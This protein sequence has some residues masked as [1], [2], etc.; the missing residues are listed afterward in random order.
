M[1]QWTRY[2]FDRVGNMGWR[3]RFRPW[4]VTPDGNFRAAGSEQVKETF[5]Y[6]GLDRLT[7]A[8]V[9]RNGSADPEHSQSYGYDRLGNLAHKDTTGNTYGYTGCQA[10]ARPAGP[11]AVC[12]A[13]GNE[14][15]YD[16]NGNLTGSTGGKAR[17]LEY[18]P[19]NKP[20]EITEDGTS[21]QFTYG[22]GRSRVYKSATAGGQSE[23]S[24][25]VGQ[26]AEGGP[27]YRMRSGSGSD[28]LREAR[29]WR[30]DPQS[31]RGHRTDPM[32][33]PQPSPWRPSD[34]SSRLGFAR[35]DPLEDGAL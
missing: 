33:G 29:R 15:T 9:Y 17:T 14:Y 32:P 28:S 19:F 16:A 6:D 11:H 25:Y 20:V 34:S 24:W 3:E 30:T 31:R 22:A 10:G 18:S 5:A 23:S 35:D 27:L 4:V 8:R 2:G 26:G 13:G 12:G 7:G 1:I 21:V